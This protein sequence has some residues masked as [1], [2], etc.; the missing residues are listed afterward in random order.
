MTGPLN[1]QLQ[2]R[3]PWLFEELK[4]RVAYQNYDPKHMGQSVVELNSDSLRV[5]FIRGTLGIGVEVASL[6]EPEQWFELGFLWYALTGDRPE[7]YL[8]GWAW[9][10]RDHLVELADAL[11]P[12]YPQTK[13]EFQ[14]KEQESREILAR[15]VPRQT[16]GGRLRRF[17]ATAPGMIVMGPVGWIIAAALIVWNTLIR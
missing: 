5:R 14:R 13:Q 10:V 15:H 9:F 11:G 7:P 17:K 2:N 12:K 3:L 4:F 16:A 6:S 8:D 1:E